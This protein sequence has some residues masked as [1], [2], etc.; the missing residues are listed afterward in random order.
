MRGSFQQVNAEDQPA[1][2]GMNRKMHT[3]VEAL[4][5]EVHKY[6]C[7]PPR[8]KKLPEGTESPFTSRSLSRINSLAHI[9]KAF[10]EPYA[11][12]P[13]KDKNAVVHS[14]V[15]LTV[16]AFENDFDSKN[17]AERLQAAA[18]QYFNKPDVYFTNKGNVISDTA[19]V[20]GL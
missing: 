11:N 10:S 16:H 8:P 9:I 17:F 15:T 19:P 20:S 14:V 13:D 3:Q 4:L 5:S 7:H 6:H 18:A 12:I 1:V 2:E